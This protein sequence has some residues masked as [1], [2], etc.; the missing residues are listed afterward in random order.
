MG[1]CRDLS[2]GDRSA[3]DSNRTPARTRRSMKSRGL[4]SI[5]EFAID[6]VQ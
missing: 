2:D 5:A 6:D 1:A 4:V 3:Y